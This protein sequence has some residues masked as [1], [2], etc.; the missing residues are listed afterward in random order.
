MAPREITL[1]SVGNCVAEQ[2]A[3]S[4]DPAVRRW[5]S[6]MTR[7][8]ISFLVLSAATLLG[9]DTTTADQQITDLKTQLQ[10]EHERVL[11]LEESIQ[12]LQREMSSLRTQ[13]GVAD[14]AAAQT[15]ITV[16]TPAL[17][18]TNSSSD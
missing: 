18:S 4:R 11:R 5:R 8:M 16:T 15:P 10:S 12:Q 9:Q 17:G 2:A 7:A 6:L 14:S 1:V 13:N 3:V